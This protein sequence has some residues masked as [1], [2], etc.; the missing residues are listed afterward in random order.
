MTRC[1]PAM[2]SR[3]NGDAAI[4]PDDRN[5]ATLARWIVKTRATEVHVRRMQREVRLPGLGD[6]ATNP[7][8]LRHA[9]RGRLAAPAQGR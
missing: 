7:W 2:S 9:C 4:R 1:R 6:A 5:A 3:V 8:R